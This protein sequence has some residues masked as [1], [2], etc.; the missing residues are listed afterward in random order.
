MSEKLVIEPHYLP[1]IDYFSLLQNAEEVKLDIHAHYERQTYRNRCHILTAHG[2]QVLTIPVSKEQ[3]GKV[4]LK[5][6]KID[7]SQKWR[8]LHQKAITTAYNNAPFFEYYYYLFEPI[9]RKE[10]TFLIDFNVELL[11]LCLKILRIKPIIT[12][13]TEYVDKYEGVS[14]HRNQILAKNYVPNCNI[15]YKQ[16][17]GEVF[18]N[19][20]SIIDLIFCCGN[21]SQNI[22]VVT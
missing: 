13:S 21:K 2:V 5:D 10:F 1:C 11:T 9:Y 8:K 17:F 3:S 15:A 16:I 18:V 6:I 20:L 7:H 19:N 4:S 14:D 22:L 12:F